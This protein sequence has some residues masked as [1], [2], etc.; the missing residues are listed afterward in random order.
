MRRAP[1][2][3]DTWFDSGSMPY[4]Q[5]H[6]PFEHEAEFQAALPGRLHLR[7]RGPDAGLV[8][9]A[10][11]D[12][13]DR[14]RQPGLPERDRERAGPRRRGPE[15]VEEPGQRGEPLGDDRAS[16]APTRS[17]S[18]CWPRARCGCRSASTGARSRTWPGSSS[19]RSGTATRSSRATRANGRPAP[20][21]RR[22]SGRWST[23][24]SLS[25]LD[26]TVEAVR[27]AWGRYDATAGVRAL[28]EFVVDDVSQWYVRAN[29][30]R[31]WAVDSVGRSGGARDAA[32]GAGHGQPAA[33]RPRRRSPATGCT[34]RWRELRSTSRGFR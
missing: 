25:R 19:T 29:R 17:G 12:R 23:A 14:V 32:R 11:G 8:L 10:A 22:P 13:D 34:A 33:R 26:A 9:L 21:P 3:I 2:V 20:R 7:G 27:A 30:A 24:G 18:I 15:D 4:A 31:F 16:S 5:W 28:M 1:E 6:Y